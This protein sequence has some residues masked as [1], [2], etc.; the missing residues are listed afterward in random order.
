MLQGIGLVVVDL[1]AAGR[2]AAVE[3]RADDSEGATVTVTDVV[4]V[5][6]AQ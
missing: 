6:D 4:F 5:D 1:K 3:L 2:I